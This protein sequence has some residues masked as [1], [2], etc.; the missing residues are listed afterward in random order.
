MPTPQRPPAQEPPTPPAQPFLRQTALP[1]APQGAPTAGPSAALTPPAQPYRRPDQP[2]FE[3][4]AQ[5]VP[6]AL[7]ENQFAMGDTEA[8]RAIRWVQWL[9]AQGAR[10]RSDEVM[11]A[12]PTNSLD[13]LLNATQQ[14]PQPGAT[15]PAPPPWPFGRPMP[16]P[17]TSLPTSGPMVEPPAA[18]PEE[19]TAPLTGSLP[20]PTAE[21]LRQ[22]FAQLEPA[23]QAND[24]VDAD[25]VE[26]SSAPFAP[27]EPD[28]PN[29]IA[30][31]PP[32]DS[33]WP[34][35]LADA[36]E[37]P[38]QP[39]AASSPG[40][41]FDRYAASNGHAAPDLTLE[42]LEGAHSADG[43]QQF[44]L[45]PGA[46]AAFTGDGHG[47]DAPASEASRALDEFFQGPEEPPLAP[48]AEEP[49]A[50]P[51][52]IA[53]TDYP[54]RLDAARTLREAGSLDDALVEYRALLK[55]APDLLP[56]VL[57]DIEAALD[58]HPEHPEL[59]SL[60]SDAR[61]RQG[62]YMAALESL[63]RSVS[64]TQPGDE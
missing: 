8:R 37:W 51:P 61:I 46:L 30:A 13:A 55:N 3:N 42:A 41:Q 17:V 58:E 9:E 39:G 47:A 36:F 7:A 60:L 15:P 25:V 16:L 1:Q 14:T 28:L 34:E 27:A 49:P 32:A 20:P 2:P 24:I 31:P 23:A 12:R 48:V 38:S 63:N 11:R 53:P 52:T 35:A 10:R 64:L 57:G 40:A 50:A 45:E 22:M 29:D 54:A 43:Y 44:T 26:A 18:Q 6:P 33:D 56:D 59:H 21:E 62:D 19:E 4:S 5:F